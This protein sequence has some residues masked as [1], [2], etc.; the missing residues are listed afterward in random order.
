MISANIYKILHLASIFGFLMTFTVN[1]CLPEKHKLSNILNGIFGL[2]IFIAGMGL[3]ARL[4]T[5]FQ[6]YIVAKL[7]IWLVVVAGA[8]V[9]SNRLKHKK[10]T[11]LIAVWSLT[12]LA[13]S[14][15]TL[16]G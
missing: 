10:N 3:M 5:G 4:G 11:A 7:V 14:L 8:A 2:L 16:N 1:I 13:L 6:P 15:A 9:A 12:V